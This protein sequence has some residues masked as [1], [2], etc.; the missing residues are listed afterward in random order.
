MEEVIERQKK[1]STETIRTK[2]A[3]RVST[4]FKKSRQDILDALAASKSIKKEDELFFN[5]VENETDTD[6]PRL[7]A[8]A[9]IKNLTF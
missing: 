2:S 7:S 9:I 6:S 3:S 8:A 4:T 5:T 1:H